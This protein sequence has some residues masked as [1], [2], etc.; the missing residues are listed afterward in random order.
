MPRYCPPVLPQGGGDACGCEHASLAAA[1]HKRRIHCCLRW[2]GGVVVGRCRSYCLHR[3]RTQ[4]V[5]GIPQLLPL[6]CTAGVPR[7]EAT[8]Q[9]FWEIFSSPGLG[10]A[11]YQVC[12]PAIAISPCGR[13]CCICC[14]WALPA[15]PLPGTSPPSDVSTLTPRYCRRG[16]L[17]VAMLAG[18]CGGRRAVCGCRQPAAH[19]QP[20]TAAHHG[21]FQVGG[22]VFRW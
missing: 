20:L 10:P 3:S 6:P 13:I 17:L 12:L 5:L 19:L 22:A 14:C 4:G 8:A 2:V 15:G 9:G 1:V 11:T 18:C 7:D 16:M 21:G